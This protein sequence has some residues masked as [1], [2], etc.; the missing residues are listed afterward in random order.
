MKKYVEIEYNEIESNK[1]WENLISKVIEE[2]FRT[3]E[4]EEY[5]L[6]ISV[7][8]FLDEFN[9]YRKILEK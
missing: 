4:M 5:N 6:Y 7:N 8:S 9:K 3:E 2:C 1:E